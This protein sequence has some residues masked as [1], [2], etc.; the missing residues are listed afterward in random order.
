[1]FSLCLL[2]F[3]ANYLCA[4]I[5][6]GADDSLR[7]LPLLRNKSVAV[8][9]N[10]SSRFGDKHMLDF[11]LEQKISVQKIFA[12][13]HGIYGNEDA[14]AKVKDGVDP[15]SG[16]PVT[17]LYGGS[18]EPSKSDLEGIDIVVFDIQDVGARFYTYISSLNYIMKSCAEN[19]VTLM[20]LDR[21]NP[22]GHLIDGPVLE[23]NCKSFVGVH[24]IPV[25]HGM[26]IG[27]YALMINGEQWIG[28][29]R[30]CS[31]LV[32]ACNNYKRDMFYPLPVAPSP[33]L[34][35]AQ[36][37]FLY[38]HLC[39][40]EGTNVSVGR[41]TD[42]PFQV[43]GSPFIKK[44]DFNFI[45]APS[46]GSKNPKHEG[47]KCVGEDLRDIPINSLQTLNLNWLISAYEG[48]KNKDKFF[49]NFF[50]KLAGTKALKQQIEDGKSEEEIRK[51]W[52]PGL[53]EFKAI[54]SKYLLY[55]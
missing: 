4:Q 25:L 55:P 39:F 21:P 46:Y 6:V 33:N 36:A 5:S 52:E 54:R 27:E 53:S 2:I 18:K 51:S 19:D 13:E 17:S 30:P 31:L 10:P 34:P 20:V 9:F 49:N 48:S 26:T 7:Y 15:K 16:L 50:E 32:I 12:L 41:G 42:F 47:K 29:S 45:P 44:G 23:D 35:N 38:P 37:V 22:N 8:V 14:G 3:S 24:P 11:L 40:F 1:M 43:Y 28:A